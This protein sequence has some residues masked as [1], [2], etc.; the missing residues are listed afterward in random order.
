MIYALGLTV[1]ACFLV[2][3]ALIAYVWTLKQGSAMENAAMLRREDVFTSSISDIISSQKT[4]MDRLSALETRPEAPAVEQYRKVLNE[5]EDF[6]HT[7]RNLENRMVETIESVRRTQNKIAARAARPAKP[8][9]AA[10]IEAMTAQAMPDL[11]EEDTF[12]RRP[13]GRIR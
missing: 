11:P 4:I 12:Q 2:T 6:G 13:F 8:D 7:V 3:I 10:Q 9:E 1:L 5:I